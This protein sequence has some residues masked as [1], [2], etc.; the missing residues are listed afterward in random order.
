MPLTHSTDDTAL[1][2]LPDTKRG[3]KELEGGGGGWGGGGR[4]MATMAR[5]E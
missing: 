4:S 5:S 3:G 2:L 1:V